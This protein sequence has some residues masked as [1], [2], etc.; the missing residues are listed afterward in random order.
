MFLRNVDISLTSF[1]GVIAYKTNIEILSTVRT[2]FH[3]PTK[4]LANF[5]LIFVRLLFMN[6]K[7]SVIKFCT[8]T[9]THTHTHTLHCNTRNW[10]IAKYIQNRC[11]LFMSVKVFRT[12]HSYIYKIKNHDFTPVRLL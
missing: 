6:M 8:Y 11:L 9:H 2:L 5:I 12:V 4:S 10:Y 7:S 3:M 1:D